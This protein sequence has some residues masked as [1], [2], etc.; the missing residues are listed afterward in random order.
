MFDWIFGPGLKLVGQIM[1]GCGVLITL[2]GA[3]LW[4]LFRNVGGV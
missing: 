3:A 1:V 4:C 2:A